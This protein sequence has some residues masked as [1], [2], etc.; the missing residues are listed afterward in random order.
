[1]KNDENHNALRSMP[2]CNTSTKAALYGTAREALTGKLA[3]FEKINS[4]PYHI[5][6]G[7]KEKVQAGFFAKK[8][9]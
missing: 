5:E 7:Q 2:K 8:S 4:G 6:T 9:A 1:M 3:R